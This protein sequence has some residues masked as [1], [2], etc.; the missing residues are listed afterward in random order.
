MAARAR[1][2]R[3]AA[4]ATPP[5]I[6]RLA[7]AI[8]AHTMA[9]LE[10]SDYTSAQARI[11]GQVPPAVADGHHRDQ[12]AYGE[13]WNELFEAAAGRRRAGPGRR[14]VRRP[15]A[16]VRGDELDRRVV[17]P[18]AGASTPR[19]SPTRPWSCSWAA[20]AAAELSRRRRPARRPSGTAS[21][22]S[23]SWEKIRRRP[24]RLV[25]VQH[26]VGRQLP[27]DVDGEAGVMA[28]DE[29][30]PQVARI[31]DEQRAVGVGRGRRPHEQRL[32]ADRVARR[33]HERD[34]AVTE[35]V[36]PRPSTRRRSPPPISS[37][38]TPT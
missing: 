1:R 34:G 5:P 25:A 22:S 15:H 26:V 2:R 11:V 13:Y 8:R 30:P 32:V 17:R 31:A 16:R 24:R 19:P 10:I 3:R 23:T 18:P 21:H 12:R 27:G 28:S 9:V 20:S 6:E 36:A 14:S 33:R 4:A 38:G 7:V 37:S 29:H 35:Q